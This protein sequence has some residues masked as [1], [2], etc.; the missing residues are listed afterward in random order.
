[1]QAPAA[2]ASAR[3]AGAV[4]FFAIRG[5]P[6]GI[7][8]L[9]RGQ[10]MQKNA[11]TPARARPVPFFGENK[12]KGTRQDR[13]KGGHPLEDAEIV[14][15]Y[16]QRDER[17]I[18]ETQTKYGG[19]CR[20]VARRILPD[21][22]DVEESVND[23]WLAAWRSMPPHRPAML[24]TYLGKLTRR[25]SLDRWR[26]QNRVKRGGGEVPLVLDELDECVPGG[27]DVARTAEQRE[28]AKALDRFLDRLPGPERDVF[29]CRYWLLVPVKEIGA[30]FGFGESK[31]KSMLARTR[32]KLRIWLEREELV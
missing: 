29:V 28:L 32:K 31:V 26:T 8:R 21:A 20:A 6:G 12:D 30:R 1:M 13:T 7:R 10:E 14:S 3:T 9:P 19:Y 25:C 4:C 23:T 5:L 18:R 11:K 16:W 15:L 24:N 27:Q 2:R 22:Q 17:A